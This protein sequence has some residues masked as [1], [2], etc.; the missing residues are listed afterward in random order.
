MKMNIHNE[1]EENEFIAE[2][3]KRDADLR[4][5]SDADIRRKAFHEFYEELCNSNNATVDKL[6]GEIAEVLK[7]DRAHA[8]VLVAEYFQ[9][10]DNN[11]AHLFEEVIRYR[12]DRLLQQS[13]WRFLKALEQHTDRNVKRLIDQKIKELATTKDNPVV[14]FARGVNK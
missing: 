7:V 6:L 11:K 14:K 10:A 3:I 2:Q 5:V 4:S 13:F 12:K 8:R 9:I 1:L